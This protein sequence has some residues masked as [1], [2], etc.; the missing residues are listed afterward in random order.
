VNGRTALAHAIM[1]IPVPGAPPLISEDGAAIGLSFLDSALRLNHVQRLTER[2]T[3][4]DHRVARRVTE[5]DL[6]LRL[7]DGSQ[8]RASALAQQLRGTGSPEA[9]GPGQ[10]W[11]PV[12]RIPRMS[13]APVDIRDAAGARLTRLTE[14]ESSTLIASGLFRL[15]R[16]ILDTHPDAGADTDLSRMLLHAHEAEW[17][18]QVAIERLLTERRSPEPVNGRDPRGGTV[19]GQGAQYRSLALRVLGK[20]EQALTDYFELFDIALDNDLLV[21]ALDAGTDEHLLTYETPLHVDPE[22]APRRRVQRLLSSGATGYAC[23][24]RSHISPGIPAYHLVVE[25]EPGVAIRRMFLATDADARV[26][27]TVRADLSV[28]AE[29]LAAERDAPGGPGSNKILELQ[30]QTTLRALA[31]L[32]RRRRW[33]CA[34]AGFAPPDERMLACTTLARIAVFGEGVRGADGTVDS[35]VLAHPQLSPERLRLAAAELDAEEVAV[36]LTLENDPTASRAHAYWH[37]SAETAADGAPIEVHAGMLLEDT[38]TSGPRSARLY[39][40]LVAGTGYLLAAFLADLPWPFTPDG[41]R[42][43]STVPNA[44]AVIS[45][46][47]LVP[48]FLYT[49]LSLPAPDTVA[50]HLRTLP[51]LVANTSIGGVALV[52]AAIG[53]GMPGLL[54]QIA[55]ALMIIVPALGAA[56]LLYRRRALDVTAELVRLGAPR[57]V[58]PARVVRVDADVRYSSPLGGDRGGAR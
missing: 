20:Y 36:D 33:E 19:E 45:V 2:L 41:A 13:T 6:S 47:L 9:T 53:A 28:L 39:A 14:H 4:I 55:F 23:E 25:T 43:L 26:V 15:L 52:A 16:G 37:G 18:I 35:A 51:R 29:R 31:D 50:G 24:Y 56:T 8:R 27:T 21:V 10:L 5:V 3:L 38:T 58:S 17:L 34:Q 44:D 42:A 49:R 57:W 40:L 46:L 7:L 54:V 22:L 11:V 12:A 48:G 30:V 1:S 32:V